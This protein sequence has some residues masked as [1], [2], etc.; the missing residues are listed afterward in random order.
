MEW[1]YAESIEES[2]KY[3][4][5]GYTIHSGGTGILM[6]RKKHRGFVYPMKVPEMKLMDCRERIE[7]GGMLSFNEVINFL[8]DCSPDHILVSSLSR[9]ATTPLRNRITIGGSLAFAPVW[10][11]LIG[12][13]VCIDAK[14]RIEGKNKGIY[15]VEEF[16]KFLF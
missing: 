3:I 2:L 6:T 12:P 10:S 5:M 11:D 7:L 16:L 14:V 1:I 4:E 9:A 15:S 13:L 8:S